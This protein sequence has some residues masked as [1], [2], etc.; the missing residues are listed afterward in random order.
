MSNDKQRVKIACDIFWAQLSKPNEMS[1]KY[2]VNLCKLSDAAVAALEGMGVSVTNKE[3]KPEMGN[4]ITCKS[5][6]PIRAYDAD[7]IE[8]T[9]NIGNNSKG[10]AVVSSYEWKYKNKKGVSPSLVKLVVTELVEY[11]VE[12]VED[13]EVVL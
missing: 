10:R 5:A 11:G 13:E 3:D 4:Y 12:A 9:G 1:G 7:G 2:Q 6:N 8:I